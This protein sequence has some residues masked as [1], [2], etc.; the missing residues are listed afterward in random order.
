[1]ILKTLNK[2]QAEAVSQL[3]G[4]LLIIAGPGS[5]KTRV[6]THRVAYMI[7]QGIPGE[8]IL[9]VTFTNKAAQ[10]MKDRI[11][12]LLPLE[13]KR[14]FKL[15]TIGTFHAVCARILRTEAEQIGYKK[16][17]VIF[18]DKDSL[19]L[20]KKAMEELHISED[21]FNPYSVAEAISTAKSELQD[22]KDYAKNASDFF[23]ENVSKIYELYQKK[24]RAANALDFDDLLM[25][26]VKLFLGNPEILTKYQ[27]KFKYILV[28]EF[29]D[30]NHVQAALVNLLAKKYRNIF[31]IGD[32]CQNI[33]SWRGAD[34]R[35][36]MDFEKE[37][38]EA[39]I[40]KLEQ[41]YR[42]TK[43]ILDAAQKVIEKNK[44][45]KDKKL[46]TEN[47]QGEKITL[48]GAE[49]EKEEAYYIIGEIVRLKRSQSKL[50]LNDF[51]V[52][53]RT[54]AQSRAI[55]EA[56]LKTG[57]PYK[58]VGSLKFYDRKEIKD[59]LAYLRL[60]QN[61]ADVLSMERII[62]V[63][64]R[65][66]GKDLDCQKL[67]GDDIRLDEMTPQ[68]RRAWENFSVL[69]NSLRQD[70]QE[71]CLSSL[72]KRLIEKTNYDEYVKTK[73]D[74]D[75]I[76][77]RLGN[78]RELFTVAKNYDALGPIE[79]LKSFLEEAALMSGQDE[80][81][82]EKEVVNLMTMHCAKGLEFPVVFMA[83]CEEG[84]FPHSRSLIDNWQME[85][86]RRLCY[87]GITRAKQKLYLIC[88]R[89]RQLFGSVQVNPPS[90]FLGDIPM[91]LVEYINME[92]DSDDEEIIAEF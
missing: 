58:V 33:Y 79:G 29:Q 40:I 73:G 49:N 70:A 7:R 66:F 11:K 15:P 30:T 88:A 35:H 65:G 83:G 12:K 75:E 67:I 43:T 42:S 23:P 45:K 87:V 21:Q 89:A 48:F 53:Y 84:I 27:E 68:R 25:L 3:N 57:I 76:E 61:P 72:L 81:E 6:L 52:L 64:A 26:V 16:D 51:A 77:D 37:Y 14:D 32:D 34:F 82:S 60:I 86:E 78:I 50:K 62:N 39:K 44:F 5:G 31:V 13:P 9:A 80:I 19:S 8:N 46:W 20:I 90:R 24:L 55:E 18:D 71:L 4:P 59:L 28:D 17:F 63:P 47:T 36:L 1:M 10:E 2:K 85:E 74:R 56:F 38:P 54:N 92:N 41:N 91:Y 69:M 22:E